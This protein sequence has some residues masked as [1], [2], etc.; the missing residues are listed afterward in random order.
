MVP[1]SIIRTGRLATVLLLGLAVAGC[2][3]FG[4]SKDPKTA[5]PA[6]GSKKPFPSL[7]TVPE[8]KPDST[9]ERQRMRI[10]EGLLADR[11]NARHADGPQPGEN[12][13]PDRNTAGRQV[14]PQVITPGSAVQVA[15]RREPP[16]VDGVRIVRS[17]LVTTISFSRDSN[18]LPAGSGA[19]IVRVAQ[20]QGATKGTITVI[21]R[22]PTR[23]AALARA[24]AV[25]NGLINL[26][27]SGAKLKIT[28]AVSQLNRADVYISGGVVP[29]RPQ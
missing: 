19:T 25:A 29:K 11:K 6:P 28:G 16:K 14:R 26:G 13:T 18:A 4:D 27:M 10:Q 1:S 8:K 20:L 24:R 17:G 9:T 22:G 12:E 2:S 5:E 7:A 15:G 3:L 21:G 23:A